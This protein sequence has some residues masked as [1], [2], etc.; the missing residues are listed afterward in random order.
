MDD[1]LLD[2][3]LLQYLGTCDRPSDPRRAAATAPLAVPGDPLDIDLQGA[4]L[5]MRNDVPLTEGRRWSQ[6]HAR[7]PSLAGSFRGRPWAKTLEHMHQPPCGPQCDLL[8]VEN[9][10]E[11]IEN[12]T[13]ERTAGSGRRLGKFYP[14]KCCQ[15]IFTA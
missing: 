9:Y 4:Y 11:S 1:I 10:S 12:V 2:D 14:C 6:A 7:Q 13:G 5:D 15:N 3:S 8:R